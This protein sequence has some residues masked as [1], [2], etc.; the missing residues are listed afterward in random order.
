MRLSL[1]GLRTILSAALVGACSTVA[2]GQPAEI[3]VAA[4]AKGTVQ[5][6]VELKS[7]P[8]ARVYGQALREGLGRAAAAAAGRGQ[9]AA[10][11]TSL[12]SLQAR[13]G[14]PEIRGREIFSVSRAF[15]GVAVEVD[16]SKLAEIARLPEVRKVHILEPEYP[17]NSTSVPFIG[18]PSLWGN[19]VGLPSTL[20]GAGIRIGIIDTGIDYQH[21]DFGGTGLL[22]DYQANDRA[23]APDSYFPTQKVVGGIDLAGDAYTGGNTPVPD[24]DPMDCNGH[25]THVAGTA[26]GYGVTSAGTAY[27]GPWDTTTPFASLR[28]G[29]GVAPQAQLYAI[30]VFGCGGSTALTVQGIDWATDPNGDGDLSDHLDVIN[31]SLGSNFGSLASTSAQAADDAALAGIVVVASAGNAGDTTFITGA[32]GSGSRVIAT[33][34]AADSGLTVG[35]LQANSP[36]GIAGSYYASYTNSFAPTP[37]P[38][39]SG[40]TANVVLA[41]DPADGAG[42]LTTDG[43]SPLT[44]AAAI[45]GN[46]ALIDRG[47]CGFQVKA[48]NAQAAGAIA[49]LIANNVVGDPYPISMGATGTTAVTIP[50]LF[51]SLADRNTIV[52]NSPVNATLNTAPAG[53][54]VATFSSRGPRLGRSAIRLKPDLAAPGVNI[55]SAQ[56]G[57]TCVSG[58]CLVTNASGFIPDGQ[59]LTI[60]GTSMAAPH[61]AGTAALLKQLHPDWSPEEIKALMMNGSLHDVSLGANGGGVKFGPERMGAGREDPVVSA[62][63]P[64][65]ALGDDEQGLVSLSF[66]ADVVGTA[67]QVRKLRVVNKGATPQTYSLAI[68]VV[69]DAPGVAFSLPGGS[70]VTVPAGGSVEL[71]VQ[72]SATG[73]LMTHPRDPSQT[74]T[75][76][77]PSPLTSLGSLSRHWLTAEAGYVV[78]SQ[79]GSPKMRVPV[80]MP[81]HPASAMAAPATIV[82]GGAGTGST[83]IPLSGTDVCTGTLGAGPTCTG[84]FPTDQVSLVTPFE[85]QAAS[86]ADDTVAPPY[87]DIQYAG[88]AYSAAS[89]VLMFGVST[90]G[91]W[92]SPTDVAFNVY[93]DTNE[94]G[95]WDR[96]LFNSNPGTMASSLFGTSGAVGQDS[97]ITAVFNLSTFGVSTQQYLN[98]LSAAG[99]DSRLFDSRAMFLAATPASLGLTAGDT[100][101]RWKVVSCPGSAPLCLALNGYAYDQVNGPFFYNYGAQGLNFGGGNLFFDLNGAALP[102]TWNTAN[103]T[104]NGS[105]GALLLHHHNAGP[106]QAEVVVLDSAQSTDL[107]VT[108][109]VSPASPSVGQNATF[110]VTV[111]NGGS[112]GATGVQVF[113]LLPVGLD[114]VSD[115]G[116][117]AWVPGTGVWTIPSLAAGA[118]ATLH[119][120]AAVAATGQVLNVAQITAS[121]PLDTNPAN[122]T[123]SVAVLAPRSADVSLEMSAGAATVLAG[124]PVTFSLTARNA[125]A[126]PAYSLNVVEAFPAFPALAASSYSASQGA[127]NPATG[128]WSF[129]SLPPGGAA[130]L[131][132]TVTA[133]AMV[134]TLAGQAGAS[135]TTADPNT[136]NN[137]ASA[138]VEVL[139]PA[140]LAATKTA[141]GSFTPGSTVTYTIVVSNSS[142]NAQFDNPGDEFVDVL[143]AGLVLKGAAASAGAAVADT[144]SGTVRW[145]GSVPGNGSVTITIS[146]WIMANAAGQNVSNQGTLYFDADGNGTNESSVPTDDPGLPGSADPTVFAA[147]LAAAVPATSAAGLALLGLLVALGAAFLIRTRVSG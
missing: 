95:T 36:A 28:V 141:S 98:R 15:N 114:Y 24:A 111:T 138:S 140:T 54:T 128:T 70:S 55:T 101:F 29:P 83:T 46:I 32:P 110:T 100:T 143:P 123:A 73:N 3:P 53:D 13:L 66:D 33:A 74:P 18:A 43:C 103:M 127:F 116:G 107:G 50:A 5:V 144:A 109:S 131:S 72:M 125:G 22:A 92:S 77:A 45:A 85:L 94:D 65:F 14:G 52:A 145:N 96:V 93:I 80:Y 117:G 129:G 64:G 82:T 4:S 88:V 56:T 122:N 69:N 134:G 26:A 68:Q 112:T 8:A 87:A 2:L 99:V 30:R 106:Q 58:G 61:A 60:S 139:S 39:P 90:W 23:A 42:P 137:A 31:M 133:P 17:T 84:T 34:A 78:L 113:D 124:S 146:A 44:N 1:P 21:P 120:V 105:L 12:R 86:P 19:T 79:G 49:V 57:V 71:D 115:D 59:A 51:I 11:Q 67:T 38:A 62:Q 40:Q 41:Q 7:P 121:T 48:N 47:T 16:A 75:Q 126:D 9:I 132:F 104:T 102:V 118:S 10:N 130:T 147:G 108:M 35:L 25:G 81:S 135:S 37:A 142:A 76:A 63:A 20:T 119:V 97:F 6:L 89:G 91:N 136:A 27:A